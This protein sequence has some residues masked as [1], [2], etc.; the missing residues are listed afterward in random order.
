MTQIRITR[1]AVKN[2]NV[3]APYEF[4]LKNLWKWDPGIVS[5]FFF[6]LLVKKIGP[7]LTSLPIFLYLYMGRYHSMGWWVVGKSVPGIWTC[8]PQVAKAGRVNLTT[9][10][11]GQLWPWH[12]FFKGPRCFQGQPGLR[13][14][15]VAHNSVVVRS[16]AQEPG[17]QGWNPASKSLWS[18]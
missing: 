5:S 2:P 10:L 15:G 14:C 16:Q 9:M 13:T 1:G 18:F 8:E 3:Q 4:H 6:S 17:C 11:S 12:C 7:E